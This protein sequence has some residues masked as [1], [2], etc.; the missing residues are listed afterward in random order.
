MWDKALESI[1]QM[2]EETAVGHSSRRVETT[3][4]AMFLVRYNAFFVRDNTGP[5][6][7]SYSRSLRLTPGI[8][9]RGIEP[10]VHRSSSGGL[11]ASAE[12]WRPIAQ[13]H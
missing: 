5:R 7:A 10:L 9:A 6:V 12:S 11:S 1:W 13:Q 8:E 4:A 3:A 2:L